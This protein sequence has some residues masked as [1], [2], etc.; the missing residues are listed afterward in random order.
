MASQV[1]TDRFAKEIA[2][3]PVQALERGNSNLAQALG[4]TRKREM[5]VVGTVIEYDWKR[6]RVGV[7]WAADPLIEYL[8]PK[9]LTP[10]EG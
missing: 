1:E 8:A 10:V 5:A 4:P 7:N 2:T 3:L 9:Y 6:L